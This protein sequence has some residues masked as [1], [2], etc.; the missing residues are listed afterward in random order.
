MEIIPVFM[1]SVNYD[2]Q[3][4]EAI[5]LSSMSLLFSSFLICSFSLFEDFVD[6]FLA[7]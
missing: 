1:C 2:I 5:T 3:D 7:S 6:P 4:D